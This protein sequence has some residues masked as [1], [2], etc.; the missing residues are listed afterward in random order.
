MKINARVLN[1]RKH[2]N[3]IFLDCYTK[4]FSKIQL[5]VDKNEENS[6]RITTG[7]YILVDGE[8][9]KNKYNQSIIAVK[10]IFYVSEAKIWNQYKKD[11]LSENNVKN[12]ILTNA[13]NGGEQL[14][15]WNFK[16]KTVSEIKNILNMDGF[17]DL[18]SY[19]NVV[20]RYKNGSN[21]VDAEIKNRRNSEPRILR[22]TMENQLKQACAILLSSVYNID[23]AF[24]NMGEDNG[25]INEFT[26]FELVSIDY[27]INDLIEFMLKMDKISRNI[28]KELEL[29]KDLI[30]ELEIIDYNSFNN[31]YD[32][33]NHLRRIENCLVINYPIVSPYI[34]MEED[35]NQKEVRW[36]MR[37]KYIGHFYEDENDYDII[38]S[39]IKEQSK[40]NPST[41]EINTMEYFKWGLPKT[42][43]F[44]LSIDRWLQL[45]LNEQNINTVA[46]PLGL[47]YVKKRRK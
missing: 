22:S 7:S 40:N 24:R 28:A 21:V 26:L 1:V 35:G 10:K 36:Y 13:R 38:N 37:G 46:N 9:I 33:L 39:V 14:E 6:N 47:D 16:R 17:I 11:N 5:M 19:L 2:K 20:E 34:K 45:C 31:Q 30:K 3:Y 25:H 32:F 27:T 41:N 18:T 4:E 43:S 15:I 12:N 42:T 44:G 8:M 23:K 29:K